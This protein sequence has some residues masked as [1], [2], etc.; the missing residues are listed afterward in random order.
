VRES[1]TVTD[2]QNIK[3]LADTVRIPGRT[4]PVVYQSVIPCRD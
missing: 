2:G 1:W 4:R 3:R